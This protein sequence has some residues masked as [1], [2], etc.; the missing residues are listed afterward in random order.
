M[1]TS[2]PPVAHGDLLTLRDAWLQAQLMNGS[3]SRSLSSWNYEVTRF[4][5][6]CE[7]RGVLHAKEVSKAVLERY[8]AHLFYYRKPPQKDG[9]KGGDPLSVS[10][11][12]QRLTYLKSWFKWLT[13]QDHIPANPAAE[14]DLPKVPQSLPKDILVPSEI[15]KVLGMPDVQD[16]IGLRDRAMLEVVYAT[17]I[18]RMEVA[19]LGVYDIDQARGALVVRQGKGRKDRVLPITRRA[20]DWV[21]RYL[22]ESRPRLATGTLV[23]FGRRAG[24]K[25]TANGKRGVITRSIAS[26]T[27]GYAKDRKYGFEM[28]PGT[29]PK[30]ALFLTK[31]GEP[32]EV[33]TL[34]HLVKGYMDKAELAKPASCHTLRHSM[35]TGMLN[36]GADI[37]F[38]QEM[39]GHASLETTQ[40]YTHVSIEKLRQ[41]YEATHPSRPPTAEDAANETA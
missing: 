11:Q 21:D 40:I 29:Q 1:N 3:T 5:A 39:L 19:R 41:V 17:G 15:E 38:V 27:P 14:V 30:D 22:Q 35:A 6:W 2:P 8:R 10:T 26:F 16:V 25:A 12:A 34:G 23:P 24:P 33:G 9:T 13:R 28:P 18:R 7:A 32:F 20:M 4:T 37:R 36:N 31:H